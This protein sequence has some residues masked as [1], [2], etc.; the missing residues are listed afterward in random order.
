[1]KTGNHHYFVLWEFQAKP[2]AKLPFERIYGPEGDW[3]VL[4]RQSPDYCGT[5]LF[6]DTEQPG[7]YITLDRW[8]SRE[9]FHRFKANH[10]DDYEVF[11]RR[12]ESLTSHE[13]LIGEFD[14]QSD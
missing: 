5:Q 12:C 10:V 11:D 7:R 2:E 13:S 9:A 14:G 1:M 3:S 6:R 4:F 8:T